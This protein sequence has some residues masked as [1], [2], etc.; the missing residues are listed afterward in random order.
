[1]NELIFMLYHRR[2]RTGVRPIFTAGTAVLL[3]AWTLLICTKL[4][5]YLV[6]FANTPGLIFVPALIKMLLAY[7]LYTCFLPEF[8]QQERHDKMIYLLISFLLPVPLPSKTKISKKRLNFINFLLYLLENYA[9]LGFAYLTKAVY[10]N[11][12]YCRFYSKLPNTLGLKVYSE[13]S[14][15]AYKSHPLYSF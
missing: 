12:H 2:Y 6:C 7:S 8:S 9:I 4:L 1:M 14:L 5:V 13:T 3:L 15:N 10:H 11:Q